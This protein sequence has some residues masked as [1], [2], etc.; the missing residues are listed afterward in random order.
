[1]NKNYVFVVIGII[2]FLLVSSSK[3]KSTNPFDFGETNYES[4]I[5]LVYSVSCPHCHELAEYLQLKDLS[6]NIVPTVNGRAIH[7]L[8][9][10]NGITWN[11]GVPI[12]VGISDTVMAVEGYPSESQIQDGFFGGSDF[13]QELCT[14]QNGVLIGEP[15]EFCKLPSGFILGNQHAVDHIIDYCTE[16]VCRTI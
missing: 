2:L 3:T 1:M 12:L 14:S 7:D 11:Y 8:L 10:L 5:Y 6:V 9:A 16:N 4:T 13:E 15:Y